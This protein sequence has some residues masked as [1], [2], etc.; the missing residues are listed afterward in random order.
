MAVAIKNYSVAMGLQQLF[1][2]R[3]PAIKY[4]WTQWLFNLANVQGKGS[5]KASPVLYHSVKL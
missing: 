5:E 3:N 1:Y 2:L 4:S